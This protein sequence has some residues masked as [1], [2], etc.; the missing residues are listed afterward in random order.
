MNN[1]RLLIAAEFHFVHPEEKDSKKHYKL[2]Q[3][4]V[5]FSCQSKQDSRRCINF[6][7]EHTCRILT[8]HS[9]KLGR[10]A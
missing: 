9:I 5:S 4:S 1:R 2:T 3:N 10:G 7:R 8:N 6:P